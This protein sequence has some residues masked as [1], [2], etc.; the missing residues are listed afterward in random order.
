[1][2]LLTNCDTEK[3]GPPPALLPVI[4]MSRAGTY[5][6]RWLVPWLADKALARSP[7]GVGGMCYADP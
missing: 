2:P 4:E 3:D 1:M 5:V 6:D 7:K